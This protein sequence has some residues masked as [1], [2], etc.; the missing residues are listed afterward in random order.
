M[1]TYCPLNT[2]YRPKRFSEVVGQEDILS[3]L[4]QALDLNKLC[5]AY[6]F[7]GA[8]GVGKT[9]SARILA[10]SINCQQRG[11]SS[12][13]CDQCESC[14]SINQG[15]CIDLIEIDAASKTKVEDIRKVLETTVY[16]PN[17]SNSKYKV[18]LIDEV[19][20]L[21]KHSFNALLKPLEEPPA[22]VKFILATTEPEK[23]PG[24]VL[25]RCLRYNL[26][27]ISHHEIVKRLK[28]ILQNEKIDYDDEK[29]L[30]SIAQHAEGSMR[31]ALSILEQAIA[32]GKNKII[33]S[34]IE[35]MLG[36]VNQD[37]VQKIVFFALQNNMQE[38]FT[39]S[40]DLA[41]KNINFNNV[42]LNIIDVI[43]DIIL[44]KKQIKTAN[45]NDDLL[46]ISN[47]ADLHLFYQVL[48]EDLAKFVYV[49]NVQTAFNMSIMRFM[50]LHRQNNVITKNSIENNNDNHLNSDFVEDKNIE[51]NL[52][53]NKVTP[54]DTGHKIIKLD[55]VSWTNFI[56]DLMETS[57][58]YSRLRTANFRIITENNIECYI[59]E[60]QKIVFTNEFKDSLLKKAYDYFRIEVAI[61]YLINEDHNEFN[62]NTPDP[63]LSKKFLQDKNLDL[64]QD[65]LQAKIDL[66]SIKLKD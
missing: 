1:N 19:H 24:T 65:K 35:Q 40:N 10:K 7:C 62:V 28:D 44:I 45:I 12:D 30:Y 37:L 8:K 22:Y 20:M 3:S 66:E 64:L 50:H 15:K 26:R 6:L 63:I 16:V 54:K 32:V 60:E 59:P 61:S 47:V 14:E 17:L 33:S 25:S 52:Q 53:N 38:I 41:S 49:T 43:Y 13:P 27:L 23:I 55:T 2:K 34:K 48:T 5:N 31:N 4:C 36:L 58:Y 29:G 9:T 57:G 39:I 56:E 21:S 46:N 51:Q 42:L 18:Y 11:I